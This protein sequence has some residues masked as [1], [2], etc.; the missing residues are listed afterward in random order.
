MNIVV[1]VISYSHG[2][3]CPF[4]LRPLNAA[5]LYDEICVDMSHVS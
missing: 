2:T 5:A 3:G 4:V 1:F